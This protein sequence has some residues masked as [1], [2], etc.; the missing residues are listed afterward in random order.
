MKSSPECRAR[1]GP[2]FLFSGH[3]SKGDDTHAALFLR[4]WARVLETG[5]L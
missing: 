1:K 4:K 2:A 5:F 3:V